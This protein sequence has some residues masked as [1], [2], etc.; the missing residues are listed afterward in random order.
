MLL[1]GKTQ[2]KHPGDLPCPGTRPASSTRGLCVTLVCIVVKHLYQTSLTFTGVR[3]SKEDSFF[4]L[5]GLLIHPWYNLEK[6]G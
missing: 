1:L 5:D 3:V 4:I 6:V 2:K